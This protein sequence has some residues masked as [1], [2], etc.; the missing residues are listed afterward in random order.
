VLVLKNINVLVT[1][2]ILFINNFIKKLV[3]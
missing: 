2:N 3:F 1:N